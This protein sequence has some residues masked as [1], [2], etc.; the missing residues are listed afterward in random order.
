MEFAVRARATVFH[1]PTGSGIH[2][3]RRMSFT[4][5]TVTAS[6]SPPALVVMVATP[7]EPANS[8]G[9][10]LADAGSSASA[11]LFSCGSLIAKPSDRVSGLPDTPPKK[12]QELFT[13]ACL[14]QIAHDPVRAQR[15]ADQTNRDN[16]KQNRIHR[17]SPFRCPNSVPL[18]EH[19][20][21]NRK[22]E[23]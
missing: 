6:T 8:P 17:A 13:T 18:R 21:A 10:N 7:F 3:G 23:H 16:Q 15:R 12:K 9:G 19:S 2:R 1:D 5:A 11:P 20:H 14:S 4:K 22:S